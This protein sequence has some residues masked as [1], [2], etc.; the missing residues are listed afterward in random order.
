METVRFGRWEL[1]CDPERTRKAYA[2]VVKGSPEECGC[3]P[4]INFAALRGQIYVPEVLTLFE[5]LGIPPNREAEIYHMARL[6]SGRH[7]YGGWFHFVGAIVSGADAAQQIAERIWQPDLERAGDNFSLRFSS[8]FALVR[9]SFAGLHLV[10]VEFT[11]KV[12]WI[13]P[14]IEPD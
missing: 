6:E 2:A 1:T 8:H 14:T 7:L 13:L 4:C 11:A 12:P 10:Q 3:E 5:K 9:E